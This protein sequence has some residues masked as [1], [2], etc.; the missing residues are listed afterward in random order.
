LPV[1]ITVPSS[2]VEGSAGAA[3]PADG[4]DADAAA[5][6]V[7][8]AAGVAVVAELPDGGGAGVVVV[9]VLV[10]PVVAAGEPLPVPVLPVWPLSVAPL[11]PVVEGVG[12][13]GAAVASGA[14]VACG[15]AN[16]MKVA[17]VPM[18]AASATTNEMI[19]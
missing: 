11:L 3:L 4:V 10:V 7:P 18:T 9:V 19:R 2:T 8:A 13:V 14:A 6:V 1:Q 5:P 15:P 16:A 17:P 12:V